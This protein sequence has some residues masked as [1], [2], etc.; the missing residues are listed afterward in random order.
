MRE[1]LTK[2]CREGVLSGQGPDGKLMVRMREEGD[3]WRVE[4]LLVT[5]QQREDTEFL[6][7][8]QAVLDKDADFGNRVQARVGNPGL[9]ADPLF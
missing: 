6:E 5:I 4:H 3:R 8:C 2:A 1:A 7:L 9:R